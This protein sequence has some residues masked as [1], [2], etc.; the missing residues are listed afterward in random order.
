MYAF[1]CAYVC[2]WAHALPRRLSTLLKEFTAT[3]HIMQSSLNELNTLVSD[4][5]KNVNESDYIMPYNSP[6]DVVPL[7]LSGMILS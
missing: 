1:T 7:W 5:A 2:Q 3:T 6:A 4:K